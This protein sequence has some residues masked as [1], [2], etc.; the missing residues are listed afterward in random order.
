MR[1]ILMRHCKSSWADLGQPDHDRPLNGRGRRSAAALGDW[2]RARGHLPDV[3]LV[4]SSRRT[5][6]TFEGLK[7]DCPLETSAALYH[8]SAEMT[9]RLLE[10]VSNAAGTVLVIGHNPGFSEVAWR[11]ARQAVPH[12]RFGDYPTGATTV[13]RFAFDDWMEIGW[14]TGAAE[15]FVIPRA[16]LDGEDQ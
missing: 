11:L 4:S 5:Q 16:L 8:A 9:L 15:D 7:L 3:A 13:F 1:L 10:G 2:L 6:E 14:G 12:P